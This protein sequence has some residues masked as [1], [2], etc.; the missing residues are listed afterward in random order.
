[1][2][3]II[4]VAVGAVSVKYGAAIYTYVKGLIVKTP[5]A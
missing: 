3:F 4:G 5:A 2:S 1:M